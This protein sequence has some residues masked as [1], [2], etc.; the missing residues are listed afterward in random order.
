MSKP[1]AP[2]PR[3]G[4]QVVR[5]SRVTLTE[6]CV[7][8]LTRA[9]ESG[10]Y[11]PGNPL[12][13]EPALAEQLG[14]SRPT[15]REALRLL[16]ERGLIQRKHGK[17]TFVRERPILKELNRNFG[18][19]SMIRAAGY[20]PSTGE[21]SVSEA[22]ADADVASRLGLQ[23][24]TTVVRV[25]RVRLADDSPVVFSTDIV[26]E[27]LLSAAD[28]EA[29][30]VGKE[31]SFYAV[32]HKRTGVTVSRGDAE[33]APCK[34]TPRLQRLLGVKP[35]VPL[36]CIRQVDFDQRGSPVVYSIEYHVAD[37]VSF[38]LERFGPGSALIDE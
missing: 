11:R 7:E 5:R 18:I 36:L 10:T 27:G 26:P 13:A 16:Q 6:S 3:S 22:A 30:V 4:A 37:W 1:K 12:P 23:V 17:G 35:G 2:D 31:K 32:L 21:S 14:V 28:I 9:I 19:T 25:E 34:A 20:T 15:L 8:A 38:R 33:L 29:L 24:G